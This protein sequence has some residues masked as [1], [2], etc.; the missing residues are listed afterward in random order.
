MSDCVENTQSEIP[1]PRLW[2]L[3]DTLSEVLTQV[4]TQTRWPG[5]RQPRQNNAA[6][7]L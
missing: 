1:L 3:N 4:F 2:D 5:L 7:V 6:G